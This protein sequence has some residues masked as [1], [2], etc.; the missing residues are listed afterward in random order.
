MRCRNA[1]GLDRDG[2]CLYAIELSLL[3]EGVVLR[4]TWRGAADPADAAGGGLRRTVAEAGFTS[5]T[6]A[7][8]VPRTGAVHRILDLPPLPAAETRAAAAA[9]LEDLVP[10][11]AADI[12]LGWQRREGRVLAVAAE[13]GLV[14]KHRAALLETGLTP[15]RMDLRPA[16]V[17]AAFW[18]GYGTESAGRLVALL[19]LR[20][21]ESTVILLR[22]GELLYSR[23]LPGLGEDGLSNLP[24]FA[25][26]LRQTYALLRMRPDWLEPDRLWLAG[27]WAGRTE[28]RERL[29]AT[30]GVDPGFFVTAKPKCLL[31]PAN[32]PEPGPEMMAA[33]GQCLTALGFPSPAPDLLPG[34]TKD[35]RGHWLASP[36]VPLI[37]CALMSLGGLRLLT[38]AS[39]RRIGAAAAW[40]ATRQER[41]ASLRDKRAEINAMRDRLALLTNYGSRTRSY[42]D[43]ISALTRALPPGTRLTR[44]AVRDGQV[45][46]AEGTTPSVSL[47]LE[48][49]RTEEILNRLRLRGQA[50]T[51]I[52]DGRQVEAFVLAGP[53]GAGEV[54]P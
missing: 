30:M 43:L 27:T 46:A 40:L 25:E 23:A 39:T 54:Q 52:V 15:I 41:I 5:R 1:I 2:D 31:R 37:L 35:S 38:A 47:L 3:R 13:R 50:A 28:V 51:R 16:A 21:E 12:C 36:A 7:I 19:E 20:T 42:L 48:R 4:K 34:L 17:A 24:S 8:S 45:E 29:A 26:T 33:A 14:E 9:A 44:L 18:H 22:D 53:F 10:Y 11:A 6:A 32:Q 49:L